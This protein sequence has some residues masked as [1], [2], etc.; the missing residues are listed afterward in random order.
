MA[1]ILWHWPGVQQVPASAGHYANPIQPPTPVG[2]TQNKGL[3]PAFPLR[4]PLCISLFPSWWPGDGL[5]GSGRYPT[6]PPPPRFRTSNCH[7]GQDP[8]WSKKPQVSENFVLF[9][10]LGKLFCSFYM[11]IL[12]K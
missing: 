4:Q 10:H 6:R 3:R 1:I 7:I 2:H 12:L 8:C 11:C 9:W 5:A